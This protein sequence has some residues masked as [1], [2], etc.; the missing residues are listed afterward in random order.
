[1]V[2]LALGFLG[3]EGEF[4]AQGL[5]LVNSLSCDPVPKDVNGSDLA[6]IS[7]HPNPH[8]IIFELDFQSESDLID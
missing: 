6:R 7:K 8:P 4:L 3:K 1:M 2:N 5:N